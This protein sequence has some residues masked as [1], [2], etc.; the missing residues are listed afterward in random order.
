MKYSRVVLG[1]I[2]G[3][4][5]LVVGFLLFTQGVALLTAHLNHLEGSY[6]LIDLIAPY[7]GGSEQAIVGLIAIALYIGF[8]KGKHVLG[9]SARSGI[10]RL[11]NLPD[12]VSLAKIYSAKY[13]ILLAVMIALGMSLKYTGVPNDLRGFIDLAIGTALI[14]G[15]IIYIRLSNTLKEK[16]ISNG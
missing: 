11:K 10:E 5:W 13:Y 2:S 16:Q 6:P 1:W 14:Q 7:F 12:P 3:G 4:V 9:K 15:A 8:L